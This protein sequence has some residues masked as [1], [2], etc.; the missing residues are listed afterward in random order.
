MVKVLHPRMARAIVLRLADGK[1]IVYSGDTRPCDELIQAGKDADLLIHE[2]T[3][4]E[5]LYKEAVAKKHCTLTEAQQ[6]SK[7]MNAKYTI[8]THF[9]GRYPRL[10]IMTNE[11]AIDAGIAFDYMKIPFSR[12]NTLSKTI[13]VLKL[14]FREHEERMMTVVD[15][16]K[17][18][19][20]REDFER[21]KSKSKS[22]T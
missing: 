6:V 14:A 8:F 19:R 2:A 7:E 4:D 12:M 5:E 1:K 17:A 22:K 15:L 20:F 3:F 18:K 13:P 10:P 11:S 16:R 21:T 9:S